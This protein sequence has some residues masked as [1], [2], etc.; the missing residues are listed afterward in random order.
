MFS[1]KIMQ[2]GELLGGRGR[3]KEGGRE[4]RKEKE[5]EDT[6]S[7]MDLHCLRPHQP[8]EKDRVN[9]VHPK[10]IYCAWAGGA[11]WIECQSANQRVAL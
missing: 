1:K 7:P 8:T 11:Q 4:K 6:S 9:F 2:V 3:E 5:T 10:N